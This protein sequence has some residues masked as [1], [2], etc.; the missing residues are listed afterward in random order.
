MVVNNLARAGSVRVALVSKQAHGGME[1]RLLSLM[2]NRH[3][4]D[5]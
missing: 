5:I 4:G 3:K 2:M 1:V